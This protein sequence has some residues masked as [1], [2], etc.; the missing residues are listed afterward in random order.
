MHSFIRT[1]CPGCNARIKA[2]VAML[3]MTRRC[4]GCLRRLVIRTRTPDD[5]QPALVYDDS[6]ARAGDGAR[7]AG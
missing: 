5:S 7:R 6:A 4:P 2:P 3:G 1:R